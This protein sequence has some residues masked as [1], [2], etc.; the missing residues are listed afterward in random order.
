MTTKQ[1]GSAP[2]FRLRWI[3][4][5]TSGLFC[6]GTFFWF[7][8]T[9]KQ[10]VS[11]VLMVMSSG[12]MVIVKGSAPE[13]DEY[14][15][16]H[17]ADFPQS[18]I[19]VFESD[20]MM[21]RAVMR[22]GA[23]AEK[24]KVTIN[25]TRQRSA[26]IIKVR[27]YGRDPERTRLVLDALITEYSALREVIR[28][29]KRSGTF[30]S[31]LEDLNKCE[32]QLKEASSRVFEF[33]NLHPIKL[34]KSEA[35]QIEKSLSRLRAEQELTNQSSGNAQS[36]GTIGDHL[37]K[38][39]VQ[40]NALIQDQAKNHSLITEHEKRQAERDINQCH[41][42]EVID[43]FRKLSNSEDMIG[44]SVTPLD[45]ASAAIPDTNE[46]SQKV[47]NSSV[48]GFMLGFILL[49]VVSS[50]RWLMSLFKTFTARSSLS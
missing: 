34:L 46:R 47:L 10:F 45:K 49:M 42:D 11:E 38:R 23:H 25:A 29:Q 7:C 15:M 30:T 35:S 2:K 48:H 21:K 37:R 3:P 14:K 27:A 24:D 39:S 22:L 13:K 43:V 19:E 26:T 6:L 16:M 8:L 20:D 4:F 18:V 44:D 28:L 17:L 1:M 50:A 5:L 41:F 33:E 40:I 31:L 36:N 32:E 9:P 12:Q